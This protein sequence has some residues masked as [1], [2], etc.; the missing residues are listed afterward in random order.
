[1]KICLNQRMQ[2]L[3]KSFHK[4]ELTLADY[5]ELRR[6]EFEHLNSAPQKH[7]SSKHAM[8]KMDFSSKLAKKVIVLTLLS[9]SLLILTVILVRFLF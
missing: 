5:R 2:Y 3:S 9:I 4:G 7:H 1:M 6:E 8:P